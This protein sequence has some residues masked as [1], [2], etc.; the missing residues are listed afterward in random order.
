M[1]AE[2]VDTSLPLFFL[3]SAQIGAARSLIRW[4]A[5]DLAAASAVSVVA[6]EAAA[7][8]AAAAAVYGLD[9]FRSA[10]NAVGLNEFCLAHGVTLA[11]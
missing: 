1:R 5:E 8:A 6:A 9:L 11:R 10:R 2:K 3:T 4:T 7:T